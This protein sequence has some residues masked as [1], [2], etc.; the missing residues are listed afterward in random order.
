MFNQYQQHQYG[1]FLKKSLKKFSKGFI[2]TGGRNNTGRIT[3][4][5][6]GGGLKRVYRVIDF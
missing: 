4:Y 6:R 3:V 5:H 1:S 2:K